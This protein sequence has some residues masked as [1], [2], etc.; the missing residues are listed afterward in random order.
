MEENNDALYAKIH[1]V[2]GVDVSEVP[3]ANIAEILEKIAAE[4]TEPTI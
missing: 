2:Y 4:H 3:K 1:E